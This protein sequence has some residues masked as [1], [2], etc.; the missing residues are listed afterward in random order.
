MDKRTTC[1]IG[2]CDGRVS[3]RGWCNKHYL[4]WRTYGDARAEVRARSANVGSC[5]VDGCDGPSRKRGWCASHYSQWQKT[6]EAKPFSYK[7][8]T[9]KMCVVCGATEWEGPGRKTCSGRCQQLLFR[10]GGDTPHTSDCT[11]C[12]SPI[13]LFERSAKS[14]RKRR[15][16]TLLCR[17]CHRSRY[18]R[19]GVSVA[20]LYRRDGDSC[21]ICG[22]AVDMSLRH[23]DLM[24]PTVD[25]VIPVSR[26]GT[27]DPSNLV[28][29]HLTCNVTKQARTGWTPAA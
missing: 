15:A 8:A 23:P 22:E 6:G 19:H 10:N 7:W 18:L 16:D 20:E 28:V 24:C 17:S 29:A 9:E 1:T 12:G 11:R 21:G 14:G 2:D 4:R 26:G 25:H 5:S 13:D 27:H 3:A